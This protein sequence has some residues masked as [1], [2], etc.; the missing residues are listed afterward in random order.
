MN[1]TSLADGDWPLFALTLRTERLALRMP[2]DDD[3]VGLLA[4]IRG[5]VV[6]DGGTDSMRAPEPSR[7]R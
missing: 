5:G 1:A 4:V 6:G 2:T 7:C 3:L